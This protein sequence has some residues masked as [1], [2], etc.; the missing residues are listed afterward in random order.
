MILTST[1]QGPD[2]FEAG[3]YIYTPSTRFPPSQ[4]LTADLSG[5]HGDGVGQR[6]EVRAGNR[7]SGSDICFCYRRAVQPEA[8]SQCL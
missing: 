6:Q 7:S 4:D 8:G 2:Q 1:N 5:E 3:T